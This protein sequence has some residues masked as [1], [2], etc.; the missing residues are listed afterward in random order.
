MAEAP[1]GDGL[2]ASDSGPA[3]TCVASATAPAETTQAKISLDQARFSAEH[4]K[5]EHAELEAMY[6]ADE[7]A[8]MT[9]KLML[10][11]SRRQMELA[12]R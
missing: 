10:K 6:K 7:F 3:P 1:T 4:A 8:E 11:R 9:K 5:D 2:A 12:D